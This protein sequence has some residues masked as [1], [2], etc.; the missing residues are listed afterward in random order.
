MRDFFCGAIA[1][2]TAM[3]C[4]MPFDVIRTRLI[5]QGKPKVKITFIYFFFFKLF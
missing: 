4:A 1:G 2:C 3:T 5:A